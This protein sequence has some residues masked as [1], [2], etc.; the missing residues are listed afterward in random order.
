M[1]SKRN[2]VSE[3]LESFRRKKKAVNVDFYICSLLGKV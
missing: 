3:S 1:V 2:A